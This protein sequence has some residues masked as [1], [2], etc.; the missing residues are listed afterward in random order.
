MLRHT[1]QLIKM[2]SEL[3]CI[4]NYG[5]EIGVWRAQ[6]AASLLNFYTNLT[7]Y[8]IDNYNVEHIEKYDLDKTKVKA[9]IN[10]SQKRMQK[11]VSEGRVIW[12]YKDSLD[13]AQ[14]I[15]D[16]FLD[17]VFIDA[18]HDYVSVKSDILAWGSKVRQG[19]I[20]CGHDYG[21]K[22]VGVKRAVDELFHKVTIMGTVW[23][24]RK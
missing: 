7:L 16:E 8:L 14:S 23:G 12:L 18:S 5:A 10:Q 24:V 3:E 6:N 4:P 9:V 15:P 1:K 21:K 19:G 17:F 11:W 20:I 13:A 22:Y 2:L